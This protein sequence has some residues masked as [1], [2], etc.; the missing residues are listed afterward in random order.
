[1]Q[2]HFATFVNIILPLSLPKTYTYRVTREQEHEIAIGKRALVQFGN[3]KIYAGVIDEIHHNPPMGYEAKYVLELMDDEPIAD[4]RMMRF[5]HWLSDYYLCSLGEIMQA[6]LPSALKPQSQTY[7]SLH[8]DADLAIAELSDKE[9]LVVEALTKEPNLYLDDI[10]EIVQ[11]KNV[12]PLLKSLYKKGLINMQETVNETYKPKLVSCIRLHQEIEQNEEKLRLLFDELDNKEPQLNLLL[13]YL[14]L[15][16]EHANIEKKL[17][18]KKAACSESPLQTLIKKGVFEKYDLHVDRL[19]LNEDKVPEV[20][21]LNENQSGALVQIKTEWENKDVV[22]LHGVT[23]SG[24]THVYVKLIEEQIAKGKQVLFLAPEIALTSQI[25]GRINKYFGDKALSYHS[26]YSSN[27]RMEIWNKVQ[28][29]KVQIIIGARSSVFLPFKELGLII[30]DEEHE[31]SY[32]QVDPAPRYQA[33]DAAI[34]LA[35]IHQCKTLL[36]SATPAYETYFNAQQ[37]KFG[38]VKIAQR[39]GN[40]AMPN[41]HTANIAEDKRTKQMTGNF[42]AQ[43]MQH[44]SDALSRNEQIILFQN[45]RGYAPI[46]ECEDCHHVVKCKNCDISLTYHKYNDSLK[47]HYCGYTVPRMVNC[48]ACGSHKVDLKGLGTEKI[49]DE[50]SAHFPAARVLRLDLDATRSKNGHAEI[51]QRFQLHEADILVGTQMLSKG[52]DFA[53][54]SLV[55]VINADQLMHFP[56]F[57][58]HERAFQ[59]LTQVSGRAGR[60]TKQG[61][62]IIQTHMPQHHVLQAV[63]NHQ[64]DELYASELGERKEYAYPPFSRLILLKVKDK[65]LKIAHACGYA[66]YEKLYN[67]L[68]QYLIGPQS[69]YVSRVKNFYI[70]EILIKVDRNNKNLPALK[71]FIKNCI[72]DLLTQK[73]YRRT[74]I[75]ADVDPS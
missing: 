11:L 16:Q 50:L 2:E 36:G 26:K 34:M 47:C 8:P 12:G 62:V 66:L 39:H 24:K 60:S 71:F 63:L 41:I 72:N 30:V 67:R 28:E 56:D 23:S 64:Y 27:E 74:I 53:G 61:E 6:A 1:M 14:Q 46:Y 48:E 69:P 43:L 37:Q 25:I 57:R 18:L 51:I 42:S 45:R 22:L 4:Q 59:L 3:K 31:Q 5:W 44:I 75:Y 17:L 38:L 9:Y 35:H 7:I 49:E 68:G 15:K 20:F 70:K 29:G 21:S 33:R 10:I 40:I 58:A 32:K 73:E 19:Y 54:V 65:D 55:G 13:A 52:L